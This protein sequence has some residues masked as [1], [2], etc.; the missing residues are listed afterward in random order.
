MSTERLNSCAT[1]NVGMDMIDGQLQ[2]LDLKDIEEQIRASRRH[3][4][5]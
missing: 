2:G 4:F 3:W 1:F 5:F